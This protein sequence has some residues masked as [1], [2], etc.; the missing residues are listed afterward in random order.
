MQNDYGISGAARQVP[1]AEGTLR[2]AEK[3]RLIQPRR[4]DAG[5]RRFTDRD[6]EIVRAYLAQQ[7]GRRLTA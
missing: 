3:R 1:C 2:S 5:R 7:S 4:D 6:I